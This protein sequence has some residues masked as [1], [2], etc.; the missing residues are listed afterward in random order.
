MQMTEVQAQASTPIKALQHSAQGDTEARSEAVRL[1][2]QVVPL[3]GASHADVARYVVEIP[4]RYAECFAVLD[5]GRKVAFRDRRRFVGWT[6]DARQP[7]YL[8][9]KNL[10]TIELR[11]SVANGH[12]VADVVLES[13]VRSL[14]RSDDSSADQERRF[15]GTDGSLVT[16][17]GRRLMSVC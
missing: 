6:R 13:A 16:L 14:Q 8:F 2:D 1:L 17:P 3:Q 4:M 9:R 11:T 7:S 12:A 10:L 15:I 5:D